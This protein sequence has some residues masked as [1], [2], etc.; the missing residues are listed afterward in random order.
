MPFF[1]YRVKDQLGNTIQGSLTASSQEQALSDLWEQGYYILK[2]KEYSEKKNVLAGLKFIPLIRRGKI[3]SRDLMFFCRQFATML[4][5]GMTALHSLS[6]LQRKADNPLL[7]KALEEV[8]NKLEQGHT[9]WESFARHSDIFPSI[10]THMI[11]AGEAGGFLP[12][13]LERLAEHFEKEHNLKEKIKTTTAY[14]IVILTLAVF[15]IF[16][17]IIKVLP[18]FSDLFTGMGVELPLLTRV[19]L[20]FGEVASNYWFI[21]IFVI[22]SVLLFS[23]RYIKTKTGRIL[24]DR[25][26]FKIPSYGLLYKKVLTARFARILATLLASGVGLLVSLE[27]VEKVV[28]NTQ[29]AQVISTAREV[30]TRGDKISVPLENSNFFPSMVVEMISI[31]EDTGQLDEM[32]QKGAY[33]LE[34]EVEYVAERLTS[35]IEPLLIIILAVIV[36]IIALSVL[37][38]M[39]NIFQYIG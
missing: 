16:F 1:C 30:V 17:L 10:V 32:L 26:L 28:N 22:M 33:F 23:S 19:I 3:T 36:G 9:L 2:V 4:S 7:R 24:F 25:L 18:T 20:G 37:L 38:P 11:E 14:P 27:L 5:S 35:I 31:G 34:S 12:E 21:I 6:T 39:F 8:T 15:V 29:F 13:V